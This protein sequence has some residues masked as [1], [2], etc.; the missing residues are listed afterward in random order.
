MGGGV[1]VFDEPAP[2]DFWELA[3]LVYYKGRPDLATP[4]YRATLT[5][6]LP[7]LQRRATYG[8]GWTRREDITVREGRAAFNSIQRA[9]CRGG[10]QGGLDRRH[11][12]LV[13]NQGVVGSFTKG[14]S[15][16][17]VLNSLIGRLGALVLATGAAVDLIWT[18]TDLQPADGPSRRRHL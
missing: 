9:V 4:S 14:R 5:R 2:D 1:V 12:F 16:Q 18:P 13:D 7:R 10:V 11:L 15:K 17:P 6:L 8:W 3:S